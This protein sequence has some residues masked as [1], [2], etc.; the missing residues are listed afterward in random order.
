MPSEKRAFVG[1]WRVV[2]ASD[3]HARAAQ[4]VVITLQEE[5]LEGLRKDTR[6]NL[7][8][9]DLDDLAVFLKDRVVE[10]TPIST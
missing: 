6:W 8:N 7:V 5:A 2:A 9:G 3:E 1:R 10:S 4:R